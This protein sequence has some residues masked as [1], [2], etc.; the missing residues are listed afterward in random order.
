M[1][2]AF[3]GYRL[4]REYFLMPGRFHFVRLDGLRPAVAAAGE[5]TMDIVIVL[6]RA[7]P[8]IGDLRRR[9]LGLFVT[10][11][12]NLFERECNIV[13]LD[14]STFAHVVH[15]DRTRPRD[16]EIYRLVRVED[17]E[18]DGP[19]AQLLPV[20]SLERAVGNLNAYAVERRPRRP[21]ED[22]R[23]R[24]QT[25]TS[26][27]GDD[28]FISV[29]RRHAEAGPRPRRLDLRALCTNRDL[30]ILDDF[31]RLTPEGGDPIARVELTSALRPP[32]SSLPAAFGA[33]K[34]AAGSSDLAWR[35][36]AQLALNHLSLAEEGRGAEPLRALV[37][38]YAECGDPTLAR[39]ARALRRVSSRPVIE[40]LALPGPI[41][42]AHG[43]EITLDLDEE[44]FAGGS[45]L[46]LSAL[47]SRLFTRHAAI[48]AFVRT[49]VRLLRNDQEVTWPSRPGTR[50]L[51]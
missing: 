42:F 43:T 30:P 38:L 37:E 15:V 29:A 8:A 20:H 39:Q 6:D 51:I 34:A 2:P 26:Y 33:G 9:D 11:L 19:E 7:T 41:C 35:W 27:A 10:P 21:G 49:K 28:L 3:E 12:V 24:G 13:E 40:R 4:L 23:R 50:A 1:R 22:E 44:V 14:P 16:F 32:R 47:L 36:I 18:S 25:R 46:L 48:N 5:E 17:A 45:T 31:P